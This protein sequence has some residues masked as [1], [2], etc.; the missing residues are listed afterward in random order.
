[1]HVITVSV[2]AARSNRDIGD[3]A[4]PLL[5][6]ILAQDTQMTI[7]AIHVDGNKPK[8]AYKEEGC[9]MRHQVNLHSRDPKP[10][11]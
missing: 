3:V 1:M 11:C 4:E 10:L 6:L 7:K 9:M 8:Q 5:D 2:S